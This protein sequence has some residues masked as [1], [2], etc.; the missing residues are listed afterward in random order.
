M[1]KVGPKS[2]RLV[3]IGW[4]AINS[5]VGALLKQR[6][7]PVEIAAIATI[8]TPEARAELPPGVAFLGSPDELANLKPDLVIEAAGRAAISQWAPAA[9][10]ASPAMITASTSAFSDDGLLTWLIDLA[11]KNG[12]RI[13]VP[14][15]AIGGIDA[16]ASAAVLGLDDV[17]H[18]IV[19]PPRAWKNTPA[20]ALVALDGL[21]ER[22]VLFTGTARQ[23]A[24]SY[25]QN[26]NATVVTSLAGLGLDRTR[27]ELIADP[28]ST[29]N[30]HRIIASGAF[31]CLDITLKNKPL[32]TNP[33]SSE[34]TALSLVRLIEHRARRVIV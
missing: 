26:A 7:T 31:G 18:Q 4:G 27:V 10:A 24:A 13:E 6:E 11:E 2:P 32:A 34:L 21:Q 14:S 1:L 29:M 23:A 20:E 9:L 22:T 30:G 19:K 28:A 17:V 33:K 12:S 25:P 5:R 15:G 16:L 8:D 3:F